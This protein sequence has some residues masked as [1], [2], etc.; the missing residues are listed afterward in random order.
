MQIRKNEKSVSITGMSEIQFKLLRILIAQGHWS[1]L[2]NGLDNNPHDAQIRG[3]LT[4][5]EKI[6]KEG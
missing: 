1:L 4:L 3:A 2:N 5:A 6:L